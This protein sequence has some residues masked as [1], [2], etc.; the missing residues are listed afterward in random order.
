MA[1]DSRLFEEGISSSFHLKSLEQGSMSQPFIPDVAAA[2][3]VYPGMHQ[4]GEPA[5]EIVPAP[6]PVGSSDKFRAQAPQTLAALLLPMGFTSE[7][8]GN[9]WASACFAA[10]KSHHLCLTFNSRSYIS[11][12]PLLSLLT[13]REFSTYFSLPCNRKLSVRIRSSGSQTML[14]KSVRIYCKGRALSAR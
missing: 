10:L 11:A 3:L 14:K 7:V 1:S 6:T 12:I 5:S 13:P 8:A 2:E 9:T 4:S